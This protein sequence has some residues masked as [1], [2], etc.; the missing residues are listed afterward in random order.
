MYTATA[1]VVLPTTII[2]SL[3]RPGWYTQNLG[4]RDFREA[5][6]DRAY[7]EQYLDAVSVYMRDQEVAGLDVV[8]EL[9]VQLRGHVD[10]VLAVITVFGRRLP[11]IARVQRVAEAVELR[12]RVVEVVLAMHL[13]ALGGKEVGDGIADGHPAAT[14]RVQRPRRIGRHELE[15]DATAA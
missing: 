4:P 11:A 3:P 5:M 2:G 9:R 8:T 1:G 6:V 15:V 13:G 14:A 12:A 10:E 7:R